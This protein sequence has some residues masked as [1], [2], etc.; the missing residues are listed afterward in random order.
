MDNQRGPAWADAMQRRPAVDPGIPGPERALLTDP[1]TLLTPACHARPALNR[2]YLLDAP[3]ISLALAGQEWDIALALREQARLRARRAEVP[4]DGAGPRTAAVLD[5][6][7]QAARL[8]DASIAPR[9]AALE[10]YTAEVRKA[11]AAYR[12][13]RQAAALAEVS[14][15]YL[16]LLARTAADEHGIAEIDTLS[17]QARAVRQ[18]FR[19]PP[20]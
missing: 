1:G 19:E 17:R 12:D 5:D 20:G 18:A 2:D 15:Q 4:A 10:G 6:Q 9:V 16:D 8:A 11:D 7:V 14:L 13:W 3:A